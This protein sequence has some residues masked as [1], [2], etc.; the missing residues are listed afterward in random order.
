M[1]AYRNLA[2]VLVVAGVAVWAVSRGRRSTP[3]EHAAVETADAN[4]APALIASGPPPAPALTPERTAVEASPAEPVPPA[5]DERVVL[6]GRVVDREGAPLADAL[7][8]AAAPCGRAGQEWNWIA[9]DAERPEGCAA[10]HQATSG[11]DGAFALELPRSGELHVAVRLAGFA[12]IELERE[13]EGQTELDL[14]TLTLEVGTVLA[15]RVVDDAGAPIPHAE[16]ARFGQADFTRDYRIDWDGV[17]LARSAADGSFRLDTLALGPTS[18]EVRA[19]G[20]VRQRR[21]VFA[22]GGALPE[23]R[24]ELKAAAPITGRVVGGPDE[25]LV[26][27]TWVQ[28][29]NEQLFVPC[30]E[31]GSFVIDGLAP[32]VEP[33]HLCAMKRRGEAS[34]GGLDALAF[35]GWERISASVSALPGAREVEIRVPASVTYR[36]RVVDAATGQALSDVHLGLLEGLD[37]ESPRK[38]EVRAS[39]DGVYTTSFQ[40]PESPTALV[41]AHR[42][43]Q[44]IA[45]GKIPFLPG[46]TH[47]FGTVALERLAPTRLRVLSESDG[48][49]VAGAAASSSIDYHDDGCGNA[50]MLGDWP[51]RKDLPG[52]WSGTTGADGTVSAYLSPGPDYWISVEH[53]EHAPL[54]HHVGALVSAPAELELRLLRGGTVTIRHFEGA[55]GESLA[56]RLVSFEQDDWKKSQKATG[57]DGT[58]VF[59]HVAPGR[60]RFWPDDGDFESD[61]VFAE[62][63]DGATIE[64]ALPLGREPATVLLHGRITEHGVPLAG[65]RVATWGCETVTDRQGRY[66]F[67]EMEEGRDELELTHPRHGPIWVQY[68]DLRGPETTVDI[69]LT[70]ARLEGV[71]RD[72]SGTPLAGVA[73]WIATRLD[74]GRFDALMA[75]EGP[76]HATESG[77]DGSFGLPAVQPAAGRFLIAAKPGFQTERLGPLVFMLDEPLVFAPT[78]RRAAELDVIVRGGDATAHLFS[79]VT[80]RWRGDE[81]LEPDDRELR[82]EPGKSTGDDRHFHF[83]SLRPGTWE[84]EVRA[85]LSSDDPPIVRTVVTLEAERVEPLVLQL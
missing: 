41:V 21:K 7:V 3:V 11:E 38:L 81:E 6:R 64:L 31:D 16:I 44:R 74:D 29:E 10:I 12:G 32:G 34:A 30:A 33:L 22:E 20:F 37:F 51:P 71:V 46:E 8:L 4:G 45:L 80:A 17:A 40:V 49:P 42:G 85:F 5:H 36:I 9:L 13:P 15:G 63:V 50:H 2:L 25:E 57:A 72:E 1:S 75:E 84:V 58:V 66:E 60:Y 19:P 48:R 73:L 78:L 79:S 77:T 61:S 83:P 26:V 56:N 54:W 68:L 18:I 76:L 53:A 82:A 70:P 39:P 59:E 14:G 62:V 24:V 47:D 28:A 67:R 55:T 27:Y 23:W 35:F 65:A 69:D 43:H 52:G